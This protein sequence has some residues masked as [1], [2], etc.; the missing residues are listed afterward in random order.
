MDTQASNINIQLL[1]TLNEFRKEVAS[2]RKEN[3]E[4]KD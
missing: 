4:I 1:E 3:Q 2:Q